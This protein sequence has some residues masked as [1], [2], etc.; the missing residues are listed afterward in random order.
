MLDL[1]IDDLFDLISDS[2][3]TDEEKIWILKNLKHVRAKFIEKF[4]HECKLT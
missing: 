3:M 4:G 2:A 1:S